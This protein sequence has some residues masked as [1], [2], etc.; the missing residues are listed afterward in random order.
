MLPPGEA[1]YSA[2]AKSELTETSGEFSDFAKTVGRV[3][4]PVEAKFRAAAKSAIAEYD[5]EFRTSCW[6][7]IADMAEKSGRECKPASCVRAIQAN[8]DW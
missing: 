7:N 3:R 2:S 5:S 4:P 1:K 6:E 8:D